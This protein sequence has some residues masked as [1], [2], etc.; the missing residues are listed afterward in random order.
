MFFSNCVGVCSALLNLICDTLLQ[1]IYSLEDEVMRRVDVYFGSEFFKLRLEVI[2]VY[3][4]SPYFVPMCRIHTLNIDAC[5]DFDC[6]LSQCPF[7]AL[8]FTQ[9]DEVTAKG[10]DKDCA[11][12]A[13]AVM[14]NVL[15]SFDDDFRLQNAEIRTKIAVMFWPFVRVC[16]RFFHNLMCHNL[17]TESWHYLLSCFIFITSNLPTGFM[18][19]WCSSQSPRI[20]SYF[21]RVLHRAV[22]EFTIDTNKLVSTNRDSNRPNHSTFFI[23]RSESVR[24]VNRRRQQTQQLDF[25]SQSSVSTAR[26]KSMLFS[27]EDATVTALKCS[28]SSKT[29]ETSEVSCL[30]H[31]I[32]ETKIIETRGQQC[33]FLPA[34]KHFSNE[35]ANQMVLSVL[36][37]L[38]DVLEQ[39]TLKVV[40]MQGSSMD[41]MREDIDVCRLEESVNCFFGT[42]FSRVYCQVSSSQSIFT[43]EANFKVWSACL[44]LVLR[45]FAKWSAAFPFRTKRWQEFYHHYLNLKMTTIEGM[46]AHDDAVILLEE[47]LIKGYTSQDLLSLSIQDVVDDTDEKSPSFNKIIKT[48]ENGKKQLL[49]ASEEGIIDALVFREAEFAANFKEIFFCGFRNFIT[50]MRLLCYL[51]GCVEQAISNLSSH[52]AHAA[53]KSLTSATIPRVMNLLKYWIT[54]YGCDWDEGLLA[55]AHVLDLYIQ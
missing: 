20:I 40:G 44:P 29:E 48:M 31:Q 5:V 21:V 25:R 33:F 42:C 15:S 22:T 53:T 3:M 27:S 17:S 45:C 28:Y 43:F 13:L 14:F 39:F 34:Q 46:P 55:A 50:P 26:P 8:L 32:F 10:L 7:V 16:L 9:L 23:A 54:T 51:M 2:R 30:G 1:H 19:Q 35:F 52:Q 4:D 41:V 47:T 18:S 36:A 11:A 24:L 38:H 6:A 49:A 12:L 37:T